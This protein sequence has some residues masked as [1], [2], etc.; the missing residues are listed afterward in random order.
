MLL[1]LSGLSLSVSKP[2]T[3]EFC[4]IMAKTSSKNCNNKAPPQYK[5]LCHVALEWWCS[6]S[7]QGTCRIH[8]V[9]TL[10][11]VD[12]QVESL[13]RSQSYHEKINILSSLKLVRAST[14]H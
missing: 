10:N 12:F 14:D 6:C 9:D 7:P 3:W 4:P 13:I 11:P 2:S 1:P 5:L 8:P